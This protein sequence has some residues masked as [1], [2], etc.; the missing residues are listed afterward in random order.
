MTTHASNLQLLNNT[1][2]RLKFKTGSDINNALIP[3]YSVETD[4]VSN[5]I[6]IGVDPFGNLQGSGNRLGITGTSH[7]LCFWMKIKG[8]IPHSENFFYSSTIQ[9]RTRTDGF[10][11]YTPGINKHHTH[12]ITA[13]TWYFLAL[14]CDGTNHTS[15]IK[16]V[17]D[18]LSATVTG[19]SFTP[20]GY[21]IWGPK[22]NANYDEIATFN[23]ALSA[24]EIDTIYNEGISLEAFPTLAGYWKMGDS[25]KGTGTTVKDE[26]GGEDAHLRFGS[27]FSTDTAP[28]SR[29]FLKDPLVGELLFDKTGDISG[30]PALYTCTDTS[31]TI[32]KVSG[33]LAKM[34]DVP[35]LQL[36]DAGLTPTSSFTA[37]TSH[38]GFSLWFWLR[39]KTATNVGNKLFLNMQSTSGVYFETYSP[40]I[41]LRSFGYFNSANAGQWHHPDKVIPDNVSSKI[42]IEVGKLYNL[43]FLKKP[44]STAGQDRAE[45]WLNG[46]IIAYNDNAGINY[47]SNPYFVSINPS[48]EDLSQVLF[49][50]L[51]F[52]DQDIS[53]IT[54]R[55]HNPRGEHKGYQ[56]DYM[57]LSIQPDHYYKLGSSFNDI[58]ADGT[59]NLSQ[60]SG[61]SYEYK[62]IF[63]IENP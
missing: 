5:D 13:D 54:D 44:S 35:M 32:S 24:A 14:S 11:F 55:M 17:S 56:G 45:I 2:Y 57:N 12:T 6:A 49:G 8:A 40:L 58:G 15:Y 18:D 60:T 4:G 36:N 39:E 1:E 52:W 61:G 62:N 3:I 29:S 26:M 53:S 25:E 10:R 33:N 37:S 28:T 42:L 9:I 16:S 50:D 48:S 34:G 27:Q 46:E 38:W 30:G 43:T 20:T 23:S 59:K 51:A 21:N 19:N 22:C 7:T 41:Y 47:P 31:G 63:G